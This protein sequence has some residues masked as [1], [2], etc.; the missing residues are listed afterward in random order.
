MHFTGLFSFKGFYVFFISGW[1]CLVCKWQEQMRNLNT[2]EL[3]KLKH[4]AYKNPPRFFH[5][6]ELREHSI[7]SVLVASANWNQ[8]DNL[9]ERER[10]GKKL[11]S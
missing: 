5:S 4:E 1:K 3:L 6:N 9:S 11:P 8:T 2:A 7:S 10:D